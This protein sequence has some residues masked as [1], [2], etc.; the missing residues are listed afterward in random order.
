[1]HV[2]VFSP[3]SAYFFPRDIIAEK[4]LLIF[5]TRCCPAYSLGR[6]QRE[7]DGPSGEEDGM[8]SHCLFCDDH[9]PGAG[10]RQSDGVDT[11]YVQCNI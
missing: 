10:T 4:G 11:C 1:M 8:I 7:R 2:Y 3:F 5:S 9:G 6:S